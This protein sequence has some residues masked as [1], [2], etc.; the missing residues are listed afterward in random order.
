[1]Q[2][3]A[4]G[5]QVGWRCRNDQDAAAGLIGAGLARG[6]PR[7]PAGHCAAVQPA[8]ARKLPF[9]GCCRCPPKGVKSRG[10]YCESVFVVP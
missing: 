9:P 10:D 7:T 1:M 8:A 6:C 4:R 2:E 5:S 3:R